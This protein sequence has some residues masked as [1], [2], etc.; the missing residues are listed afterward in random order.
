MTGHDVIL[1]RVRKLLALATSPNAHEAAAAAALAQTLIARHRLQQWLD[2][3]AVAADEAEAI[4]DA[5]DEPLDVARKPRSWKVALA[6]T[7]ADAN[8]C[9]AYTLDRG[10]ERAIVL[11][12]RTADRALVLELWSWL[13]SRIEWLSATHGEGRDRKWHDAFRVGVVA[14]IGERL[15]K[16]DAQVRGELVE[17]ALVRLDPVLLA[18][19]EALDRFVEQRLRLGRGRAITV[20]ARAYTEGQRAGATLDLGGGHKRIAAKG[21]R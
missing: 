17:G 18:R 16:V 10:K 19:R 21:R 6:T 3:D 12:G 20:D 9:V 1:D 15:A 14:A 11:V 5:R 2:A 4:D 13:V 7:L 8:G